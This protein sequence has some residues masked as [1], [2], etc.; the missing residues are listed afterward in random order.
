MPLICVASRFREEGASFTSAWHT[1]RGERSV[2]FRGHKL[3]LNV[4]YLVLY[5]NP[6][7]KFHR[8]PSSRFKG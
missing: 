7:T 4:R 1:V 2:N 6:E 5:G 3:G 8:N